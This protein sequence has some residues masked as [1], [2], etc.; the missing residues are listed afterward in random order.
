LSPAWTG[1]HCHFS[2]IWVL[3][4]QSLT[5]SLFFMSSADPTSTF[6]STIMDDEAAGEGAGY[7]FLGRYR[8]DRMIGHGAMG[9][10]FEAF[11][12]TLGRT[13]AIKTLYSPVSSQDATGSTFDSATIDAAILKEARAAAT[14]NHAHIVTVYDAG[15]AL[16]SNLN[17]ELPYVAMELLDGADLRTRLNNGQ[18][19]SVRETVS[20]VGKLALALDHAHKAGILHRD[21]KPA[22]IFITERAGPKL[23]DFGLAQLTS[24]TQRQPLSDAPVAADQVMAGSPQYMSPEAITGAKAGTTLYNE[25]SD[26]YSLGVVFYE[27]LTG[28]LPYQA[29]TLKQLQENILA[30]GAQAAHQINSAIPPELSSLVMKAIAKSASQRFRSA[31]QMARELRRWGQGEG[32][33]AMQGELLPSTKPADLPPLSEAAAAQSASAPGRKAPTAALAGVAALALAAGVAWWAFS[34]GAAPTATSTTTSAAGSTTSAASPVAAKP[35]AAV[36]QTPIQT[37]APAPAPAATS[38]PS[39]VA[40]APS[41]PPVS[42]ARSSD[43]PSSGVSKPSVSQQASDIDKPVSVAT[44]PAVTPT[45]VATTGRVRLAIQPWGEVEVNGKKMGVSPPLGQLTLEPGSH[46]ITVRNADFSPRSFT[47]QVETGKTIRVN[48]TFQ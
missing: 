9:A 28:Q 13:L 30:G 18:K 37:P 36:I 31:G 24:H 6:A 1:D 34:P 43:A 39:A 8:L 2:R 26:V 41:I 27:L 47:V 10:V 38:S 33:E 17:R 44:A 48:H 23:V 40:A 19:F 12:A 45:A 22:N 11:D 42:N 29:T 15:R 35:Q 7:G 21:I 5:K 20:L 3:I 25:Q 16:S 4:E 46:T 14:L 32:A